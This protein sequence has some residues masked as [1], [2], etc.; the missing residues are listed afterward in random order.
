MYTNWPF[1]AK[2]NIHICLSLWRITSA[3][4][5][6]RVAV[7]MLTANPNQAREMQFMVKMK[8]EKLI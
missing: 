6:L 7:Y 5:E 4:G 1:R 3:Y 8:E 2:T